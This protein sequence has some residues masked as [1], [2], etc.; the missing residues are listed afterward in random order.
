MTSTYHSVQPE[1]DE[2]PVTETESTDTESTDYDNY[3][4][5]DYETNDPVKPQRARNLSSTRSF[6][7]RSKII[8]SIVL[9]VVLAVAGVA[10]GGGAV[11]FSMLMKES[12]TKGAQS[13]ANETLTGTQSDS[14]S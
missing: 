5:T 9:V 1:P 10:A 12:D 7:S 4:D 3:Y 13:Q 11:A 6:S 14:E 2:A 8:L